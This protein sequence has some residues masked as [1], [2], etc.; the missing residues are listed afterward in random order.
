[1]V[2]VKEQ[3]VCIISAGGT[4]SRQTPNVCRSNPPNNSLHWHRLSAADV[5]AFASKVLHT[6][7]FLIRHPST[8]TRGML[9]L[10]LTEVEA[11]KGL[12]GLRVD[13]Q[14]RRDAVKK[15]V[16]RGPCIAAKAQRLA[17]CTGPSSAAGMAKP[18]DRPPA[19]PPSSTAALWTSHG[20]S[21]TRSQAR[22]GRE[23]PEGCSGASLRRQSIKRQPRRQ[24]ARCVES[25]AACRVRARIPRYSRQA[26]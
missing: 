24:G 16:V 23:G 20:S 22:V 18:L 3:I 2:P 4:T 26:V 21:P 8:P 14:R 9:V 13:S 10:T 1:M 12:D 6:T 11:A 15:A 25:R 5:S 7:G 19:P 17:S